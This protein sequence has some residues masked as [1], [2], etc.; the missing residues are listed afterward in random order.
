MG[1]GV[2]GYRFK[3]FPAGLQTVL[4]DYT[5]A[6]GALLVTG[7]YVAT[8]LWL[9]DDASES[10]RDFARNVLHYSFGGNMATRRGEVRAIPSKMTDARYD[11]RFACELNDSIYCVE[12][13]DIVRPVGKGSFTALRYKSNNQSAA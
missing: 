4:R 6:G 5:D 7:A 8:D 11:L 12:S 9:S 13:P 10:D 2:S 3:T 1:R